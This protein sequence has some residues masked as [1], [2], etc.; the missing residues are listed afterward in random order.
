MDGWP[1]RP[2]TVPQN[3]E[4]RVEWCNKQLAD[5]DLL[6]DNVVWTDECSVQLESHRLVTFQKKVVI[7]HET[8][9]STK[10]PC[11]GWYIKAQSYSSCGLH[12]HH[13][14]NSVC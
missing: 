6:F 2:G 4:A 1:R 7:L 12:R 10:G 3:K 13:E 14:C 9:T 11:L 8:K 5:G